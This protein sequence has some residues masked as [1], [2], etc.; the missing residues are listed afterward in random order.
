MKPG[1]LEWTRV[2]ADDWYQVKLFLERASG[3]SMD[4]LH[5]IV[6]VLLQLAIAA[7]FRTSVARLLPLLAV[8]ALELVNEASD[9]RV[10][11]WPQPGMQ[12][13]ESA[14]DIILTMVLPTLIFLVAR[15]RPKV[16]R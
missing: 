5:V 12:L 11:I 15:Y 1:M 16:L 2:S 3:F 4:A 13:G 14:K 10:E 9:F 7:L 6:G 8:L